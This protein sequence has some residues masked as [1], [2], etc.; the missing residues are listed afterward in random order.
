MKRKT[1]PTSPRASTQ[2]QETNLSNTAIENTS[3]QTVQE[4][5]NTPEPYLHQ[6]PE[7]NPAQPPRE[8][9]SK[10]DSVAGLKSHVPTHPQPLPIPELLS[11][12]QV[13][14]PNT[15]HSDPNEDW[16]KFCKA[17]GELVCCEQC[18]FAWHTYCLVPPLKDV[19]NGVW[20]C[21]LCDVNRASIKPIVL[22]KKALCN[23]KEK[24]KRGRK[25]KTEVKEKE[26]K[27]VSTSSPWWDCLAMVKLLKNHKHAWPFAEPVNPEKL[28]IPD[29]HIYVSLPMD[30]ST[31]EGKLYN[32][33]Y[34]NMNDFANDIRLIWSNAETY[35]GPDHLVT[36]MAYQLR[37]IFEDV[38][39][40][41]EKYWREYFVKFPYTKRRLKPRPE[42]FNSVFNPCNFKKSSGRKT[43]NS[44]KSGNM[45]PQNQKT[46]PVSRTSATGSYPAYSNTEN[47]PKIKTYDIPQVQ[48]TPPSSRVVSAP[49]Q[50][51]HTSESPSKR[52]N[53]SG[54]S[55]STP[56]KYART[57]PGIRGPVPHYPPASPGHNSSNLDGKSLVPT[58]GPRVPVYIRIYFDKLTI[59]TGRNSLDS[60]RRRLNELFHI[61]NNFRLH[62]WDEDGTTKIDVF[63]E[64]CFNIFLQSNVKKNLIMEK[65]KN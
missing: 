55:N 3:H 4:F 7:E 37:E 6:A 2:V 15:G 21:P 52:S 63:D 28:N 16:C 48:Q 17:T 41:R 36:T 33:N 53:A 49:R 59:K 19:P 30:L 23:V 51:T 31:V 39:V 62:Y 13:V 5:Q 10:V 32:Q 8:K 40:A 34:R 12:D 24:G 20:I 43:S 9:L 57:S 29:Y 26:E 11:E 18:P 14:H 1:P 44:A 54:N 25:K 38:F 35:N 27:V 58:Q 65:T 42:S 46:T 61:N 60:L 56:T 64:K 45:T 22:T 47:S 50:R